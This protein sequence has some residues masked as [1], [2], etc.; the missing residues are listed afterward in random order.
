MA[1]SRPLQIVLAFCV[2][3]L[4]GF[5]AT[6]GARNA[7]ESA[8]V[9]TPVTP[10]PEPQAIETKQSADASRAQAKPNRSDE[11]AKPDRARRAAVGGPAAAQRAIRSG[12]TVVLYFHG[13]ASADES[14]TA[15][16]VAGLDGKRDVAVLKVPIGRLNAYRNMVGQLGI[17][18]APAVVI[19]GRDRAARVIEGYIDPPTLAQD[20]ADA[21]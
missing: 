19:V 5:Y 2:L 17:A 1:I 13:P 15:K 16:A 11:R 8:D 6:Q 12:K 20:V 21:R 3:A 4:V 9:A 14:A 18:Q 7:S 10:A